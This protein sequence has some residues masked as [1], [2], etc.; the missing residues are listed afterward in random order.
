MSSLIAF[1]LICSFAPF[2]FAAKVLKANNTQALVDTEGES[3]EAGSQFYAINPAGKKVAIMV[4]KQVKGSKALMTISKGR[5]T[6]GDTVQAKPATASAADVPVS[7]R[8]YTL[9][10]GVMAGY[11]MSNMSMS[12][13]SGTLKEDIK[14][15]DSSFNLKVFADYDLSPSLTVRGASGYETFAAKGTIAQ[16]LCTGSSTSC[17]AN[18]TYLPLEGSVHYNFMTGK[19]KAWAGL[20][21]SF[22]VEIGRDVNIPN[23]NSDS[24]TNQMILLGVGADFRM[25][26]KTFIPVV[27][28]YATFPGSTNVTASAIYLRAGYGFGF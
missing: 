2:S 17:H 11:A 12:V 20:G 22:L 8:K 27:L 6:A 26:G 16:A 15:S 10:G 4:A 9:A 28:E 18:Y 21:Y 13:Q 1:I 14:M 24:K 7:R 25:S 23:L 19:T 3:I 5:A